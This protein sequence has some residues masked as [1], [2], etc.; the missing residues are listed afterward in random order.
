VGTAAFA[1]LAKMRSNIYPDVDRRMLSKPTLGHGYRNPEGAL[2]MPNTTAPAPATTST[3]ASL[4]LL[5]LP[6]K[7]LLTINQSDIP[8][9]K[10]TVGPGIHI[11][12]LRLDFE[13]NEW[14]V[15]V[16]FAPGTSLPLHYHT[17][18]A[19]LYTLKGRW[20]YSEYPDQPQSAGSYL[21]EPGGSVHTLYVPKGNTEDTVLFV[22]VCGANI[23]FDDA[24]QLHS[25]LDTLII[26]VIA[27]TSSAAQ[28]LPAPRYIEGGETGFSEPT[29]G[30]SSG[31]ANGDARNI[32]DQ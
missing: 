13:H 18:P 11:Q 5:A 32:S 20:L 9:I 10:D 16:T 19:E 8:V 26:R 31:G 21:Y 25:V 22:R 4:P 24:G 17:G 30:A 14:V 23:N 29:L 3:G 12:V 27:E 1:G 7:R 28:D 6:Q 2:G 15:L